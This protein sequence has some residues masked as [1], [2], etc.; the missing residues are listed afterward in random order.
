LAMALSGLPSVPSNLWF[1]TAL[2]KRVT[3]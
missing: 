3:W 2:K 1:F